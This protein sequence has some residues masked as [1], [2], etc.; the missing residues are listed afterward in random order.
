MK[1]L[2]I[3]V[4]YFS[5]VVVGLVI[6]NVSFRYLDH[7]TAQYYWLGAFG[8]GLTISG[9]MIQVVYSLKYFKS[10]KEKKSA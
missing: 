1:N 3:F 2:Q 10:I 7:S 6:V 4:I 8:M 9:F 5:M